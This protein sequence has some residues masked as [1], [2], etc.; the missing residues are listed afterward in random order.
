MPAE[1][2]GAVKMGLS[3]KIS[4]CMDR[5]RRGGFKLG[6]NK[7]RVTNVTAA[8]VRKL[9]KATVTCLQQGVEHQ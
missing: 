7:N 9:Q 1:S 3:I 6:G 2:S 8:Q 4:L 5:W